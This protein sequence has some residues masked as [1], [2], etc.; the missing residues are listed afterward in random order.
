MATNIAN[1]SFF[2]LS[3]SLRSFS[4]VFFFFFLELV[5]P[6]T[7]QR[8]NSPIES[9]LANFL[10]CTFAHPFS[11]SAEGSRRERA[12]FT[13]LE[14]DFACPVKPESKASIVIFLSLS[15]PSPRS[16]G[17]D[18]TRCIPERKRL[19]FGASVGGQATVLP[20]LKGVCH[21]CIFPGSRR[22]FPRERTLSLS[23]VCRRRRGS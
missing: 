8:K 11:A 20:F 22:G 6:R 4:V 14:E 17:N 13:F 9:D 7:R 23:G 3:F 18:H 5:L 19:L 2:L 21:F 10:P 1:V 16:F 12:K 15:L